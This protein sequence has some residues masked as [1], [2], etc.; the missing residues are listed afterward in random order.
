MNA[1]KCPKCGHINS[2]EQN[3]CLE[4]GGSIL[5]MQPPSYAPLSSQQQQYQPYQS[6]GFNVPDN[7]KIQQQENPVGSKVYTWY[8][9]FCAL[10]TLA[11]FLPI[12]MGI[13][14]MI[15]S[16]QEPTTKEQTDAFT[17]GIMFIFYGLFYLVPYG[18]G[19]ILPNRPFHWIYGLLLICL[20][21]TSCIF[22]PFAI[23]LLLYWIK[24]ETKAFMGR[25]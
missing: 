11:S 7:F 9:V 25:A 22:L 23:P 17:G 20:G 1:T 6:Y 19:L 21:M 18:F 14:A 5:N 8:K 12:I 16:A 3:F 2:P 10:L 15:G 24:P 4:C 13:L